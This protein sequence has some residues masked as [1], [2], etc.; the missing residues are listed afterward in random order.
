MTQ[1]LRFQLIALECHIRLVRHAQNTLLHQISHPLDI[2]VKLSVLTVRLYSILFNKLSFD[3]VPT[4][5]SN[6]KERTAFKFF[7]KSLLDKL[8]LV[9]TDAS[10]S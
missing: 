10:I 6:F 3:R 7:S 8:T 4:A 9:F 2:F 5:M 1:S